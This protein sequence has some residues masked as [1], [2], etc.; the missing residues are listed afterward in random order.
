MSQNDIL[1]ALTELDPPDSRRADKLTVR[2]AGKQFIIAKKRFVPNPFARS[3]FGVVHET[4]TGA[5]V[6]YTFSVKPA[7]RVLFS[8][9]FAMM[10][11]VLLTGLSAIITSGISD[12]RLE[13]VVLA[14]AFLASALSAVA[15]CLMVSR[16]DEQQ[17]ERLLKGIIGDTIL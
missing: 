1:K 13:L 10:T 9:W 14:V 7:V 8:L 5:I 3:L 15:V 12:Y 16:K 2:V 4:S 11:V 17:M 6:D